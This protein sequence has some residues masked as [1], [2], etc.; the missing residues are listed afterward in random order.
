MPFDFETSSD[1]KEIRTH[2]EMEYDYDLAVAL[3]KS[4]VKETNVLSPEKVQEMVNEKI[5]RVTAL[6]RGA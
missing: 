4:I 2:K 5:A 6:Y 1:L 3:S